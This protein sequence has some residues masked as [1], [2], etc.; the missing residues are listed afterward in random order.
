MLNLP[1]DNKMLLKYIKILLVL[2]VC[3]LAI[4]AQGQTLHS[5]GGYVCTRG[6]SVRV[7]QVQVTNQRTKDANITD[8][9]GTFL[10]KAA[11]GDTLI[12]TKYDFTTLKFPV[13]SLQDMVIFI[14]QVQMLDNV[15]IK[16]ETKKQELSNAM[17]DYAKK[18]VYAGGKPSVGSVLNSPLNGLYSLFGREP[19]NARHFAEYAKAEEEAAQDSRKFNKPLIKRITNIPDED[20]QKFMDAYKPQHEDLMKWTDYEIINYIKKSYDDF[21]K[22]PISG[23]PKLY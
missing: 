2:M 8:D 20:M 12:F 16:G 17:S 5:I 14:Q 10:I 3:S 7:A 21:K 1:R 15:T 19:K 6:T 4:Q 13:I 11:I 9:Q 22:R 18:G 23:L